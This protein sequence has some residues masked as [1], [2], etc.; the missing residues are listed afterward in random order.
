MISLCLTPKTGVQVL[1]TELSSCVS[2]NL[3]MQL[4]LC[5]S[6]QWIGSLQEC[7]KAISLHSR[8]TSTSLRSRTQRMYCSKTTGV[9][10]SHLT[11][12]QVHKHLTQIKCSTYTG[13]AHKHLECC[14]AISLKSRCTSTSLRLRA[15]RMYCSQTPGDAGHTHQSIFTHLLGRCVGCCMLQCW[16]KCGLC[17][18]GCH[19]GE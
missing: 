8:C 13:I 14:K 9:L 17:L 6:S 11:P 7:C 12:K 19:C 18:L 4:A 10:Q 2:C 15:Q 3:S 1:H 16:P 5:Y